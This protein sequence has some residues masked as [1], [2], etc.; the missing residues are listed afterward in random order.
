MP[1]GGRLLQGAG[2]GIRAN[3]RAEATVQPHNPGSGSRCLCFISSKRG[4]KEGMQPPG[5]GFKSRLCA[6]SVSDTLGHPRL[7]GLNV[8]RD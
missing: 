8:A 6:L 5:T 3:E 1:A 7:R 4:F 2:R